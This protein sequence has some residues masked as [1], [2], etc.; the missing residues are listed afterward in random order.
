MV[1]C[2]WKVTSE[3]EEEVEQSSFSFYTDAEGVRHSGF[4][5]LFIT[6]EGE[7]VEE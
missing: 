1:S 5:Y 4:K 3:N 6:E 7:I 2:F